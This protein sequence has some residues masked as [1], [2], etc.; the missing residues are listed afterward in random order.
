MEIAEEGLLSVFLQFVCPH[1][2]LAKNALLCLG[3]L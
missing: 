2:Q 1:L 3:C